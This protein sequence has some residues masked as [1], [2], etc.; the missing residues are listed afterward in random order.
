MKLISAVRLAALLLGV[1][2]G[3]A[4][5]AADS[6]ITLVIRNNRF[7]PATVRVPAGQRVKLLVDNQDAT[8]EEFE[9]HALNREK[10][11]P[12]GTRTAL[13]VGPL[14]PGSYS[15]YGEYHQSSAQGAL[16]AE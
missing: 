2:L 14:P 9:S 10:I 15:F 11:V 3:V 7:E 1:T 16:I 13:F 4:S 12:A 5:Q 6:E 8:A